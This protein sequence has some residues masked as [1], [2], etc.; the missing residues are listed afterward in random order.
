[1]RRIRAATGALLS[2]GVRWYSGLARGWLIAL[3]SLVLL[4]AV[5]GSVGMYRVYD[6]V[7]HD[8]DFCTGCHLMQDPF[9][10]FAKSAHRGLGCKACHR[11]NIWQRST[12]GLIQIVE[13]PDSLTRHAEV[14]SE[15]C[16]ECHVDGN[17]EEWK[18]IAQ[19]AGHRV[20]L[21]S[22]NPKL[23]KIECLTCHGAGVHEFATSDK[24]C[25]QSECHTDTR[26]QLGG[27]SKLAIH[28]ASC[29]DFNKPVPVKASAD[30]I[31]HSLRPARSDCFGCH[32][33]RAKLANALPKDEPHNA[34]CGTCH[35]PHE[36]NTPAAAV[37]TCANGGCHQHVDT[38]TAMHR[39]LSPGVLQ[40]CTACH[41]AHSWK[42]KGSECSSCHKPEDL[43]NPA[44]KPIKRL[45]TTA[46]QQ[47]LFDMVLAPTRILFTM[48]AEPPFR[49]KLHASV[50]CKSCHESDDG[51]GLLK[52]RTAADCEG[53]H[54]SVENRGRCTGCHTLDERK[55]LTHVRHI[56]RQCVSCHTPEDG[57]RTTTACTSC[58]AD[59]HDA[60]RTC[61]ACHNNVK[62]IA[63]HD[64]K[65]H[66]SCT[67]AGCH[68]DKV[69]APLRT[70]RNVCL[71]C[72]TEQATHQP[73]G[74]CATCHMIPKHAKE[75][76][77]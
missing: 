1:M 10:R 56:T 47:N 44:R 71:A 6:Y 38:V 40:N 51:H 37:T 57:L 11:P 43:D 63:G 14:P 9:E 68:Q 3:T 50:V 65:V 32:E 8:N 54:H 26:I 64:A 18:L 76:G 28:C 53:C 73:K 36:Q 52:I 5:T 41:V 35:N 4:V 33:M 25:G 58:H 31:T 42:V 12:M 21:E 62:R 48:L 61:T 2:G 16:A 17:P 39:D 74:D 67:N 19:S 24:S 69:T 34:V 77:R 70:Q 66:L 75:A 29:H 30:S 20:H 72:H 13:R 60:A 49:H 23:A 22:D 45:H 27:M 15:L 46:Q 59:H 55:S 7:Q